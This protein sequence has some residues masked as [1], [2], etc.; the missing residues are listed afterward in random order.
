[1]KIA[2]NVAAHEKEKKKYDRRLETLI[3]LCMQAT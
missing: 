1:M 2:L 3:Y